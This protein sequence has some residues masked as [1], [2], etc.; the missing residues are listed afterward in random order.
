MSNDTETDQGSIFADMTLA[1]VEGLEKLRD[2]AWL[3]VVRAEESLNA[4]VGYYERSLIG[5][6]LDD[7]DDAGSLLGELGEYSHRTEQYK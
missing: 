1:E 3:A 6:S 7:P 4:Y 2:L 5:G